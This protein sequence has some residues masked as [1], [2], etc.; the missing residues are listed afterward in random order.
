ML[1]RHHSLDLSLSTFGDNTTEVPMT[2]PPDNM[3]SGIVEEIINSADPGEPEKAQIAI[4]G[5]GERAG[6]I[7]IVNTLTQKNGDET[8]LAKGDSVKVTIK[9]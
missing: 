4:Q 5:A 2:N 8:S 9:A 1:L 6:E 3:L 7:R